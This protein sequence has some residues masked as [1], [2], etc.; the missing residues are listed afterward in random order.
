ML[1]T[2]QA[3][4]CAPVVSCGTS[5]CKTD[6]YLAKLNCQL[7]LMLGESGDRMLVAGCSSRS[8]AWVPN[9]LCVCLILQQSAIP[10]R[11]ARS[12]F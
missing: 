6:L 1:V 3:Q 7:L 8:C 4:P 2:A 9:F 11:H 10:S 5:S 12:I